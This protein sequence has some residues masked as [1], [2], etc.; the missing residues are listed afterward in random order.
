MKTP[1]KVFYKEKPSVSYF[2]IFGSVCYVIV[3]DQLRAKMD[4]KAQKY[5]F[6]GY[7]L[8]RKGWRCM[9]PH[10]LKVVTSR[11]VVFD[12]TSSYYV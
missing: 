10:T 5:V 4:A 3:F 6:V 12:E 11:D 2:R 9:D 1:Y 8:E 7:D